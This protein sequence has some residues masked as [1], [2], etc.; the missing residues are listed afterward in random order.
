MAPEILMEKV[1][2]SYPVDWFA[3]GCSIYEMVA[4]RTP[5]R[6]YKEQVSKEDLRQRTLKE[7]VSFQH[8]DFTNDTKDICW[9]LLAEKPEQHLGSR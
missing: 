3:M 4:G 5:F 9:L 6:D 1:S 7:E 8:G 2:Y